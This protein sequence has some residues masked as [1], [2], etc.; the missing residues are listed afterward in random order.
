MS[1]RNLLGTAKNDFAAARPAQ[2]LQ[3]ALMSYAANF[4]DGANEPDGLGSQPSSGLKAMDPAVLFD[5]A[6]GMACSIDNGQAGQLWEGGSNAMK[7]VLCRDRF[8]EAIVLARDTLGIALSRDWTAIHRQYN[9]DGL[10]CGQYVSVE[11][12]TYFS[13]GRTVPETVLFRL[14]DDRV[15]R[16]AAYAVRA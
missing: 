9:A 8:S 12:L 15:W 14:D 3:V 4:L 6:L 13:R 2:D 16:F 1:R 7:Q 11:F 5:T 10:P